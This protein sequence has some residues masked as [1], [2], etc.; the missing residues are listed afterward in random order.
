[1]EWRG[2][3]A[4][5]G[6]SKEKTK[7]WSRS[8]KW[9]AA[10]DEKLND[11]SMWSRETLSNYLSNP[12]SPLLSYPTADRASSHWDAQ[13][14]G[15]KW[16]NMSL[17][18]THKCGKWNTNNKLVFKHIKGAGTEKKTCSLHLHGPTVQ[19]QL[20]PPFCWSLRHICQTDSLSGVFS[21]PQKEGWRF[22][23]SEESVAH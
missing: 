2:R 22:Q 9:S 13:A 20:F 8:A 14:E 17:R 16:G 7:V 10:Q 18:K 15:W 23:P 5:E 1:M 4:V 12:S 3:L 6:W 21:G 19:P 11:K